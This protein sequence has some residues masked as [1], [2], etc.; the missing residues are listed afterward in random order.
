MGSVIDEYLLPFE[1]GIW[2]GYGK[3]SSMATKLASLPTEK[4]LDHL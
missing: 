2:H 3:N 1:C 4:L